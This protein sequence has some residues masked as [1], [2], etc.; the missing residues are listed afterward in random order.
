MGNIASHRI[1]SP[2]RVQSNPDRIEVEQ[3]ETFTVKSR[4]RS[5]AH[6]VRYPIKVVKNAAQKVVSLLFF[7]L[8]AQESRVQSSI[9]SIPSSNPSP[10]PSNSLPFLHIRTCPIAMPNIQATPARMSESF[11][12]HSD[13]LKKKIPVLTACVPHASPKTDSPRSSQATS[14]PSAA[15]CQYA[16]R[17]DWPGVR[18]PR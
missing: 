10:I 1:A 18:L 3:G 5:P 7:S 12:S 11:T 9:P 14:G 13:Q 16:R 8:L 4:T 2:R 17:R 15:W 6:T